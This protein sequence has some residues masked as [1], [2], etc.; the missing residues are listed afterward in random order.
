[1]KT[2]RIFMNTVIKSYV[3][4]QISIYYVLIKRNIV[5]LYIWMFKVPSLARSHKLSFSIVF[6]S[7]SGFIS[8]RN[9]KLLMI[10]L[11]FDIFSVFTP[12]TLSLLVLVAYLATRI[13][14]K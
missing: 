9:T 10:L 12:K 14:T 5:H 2:E 13:K 6:F 8:L 3:S 11:M 7:F 1:M 4:L